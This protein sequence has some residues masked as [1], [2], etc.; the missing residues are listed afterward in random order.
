M[1]NPQII[2]FSVWPH[3]PCERVSSHFHY[4]FD[5][6]RTFGRMDK[7]TRLQH[8]H[9]SVLHPAIYFIPI[10]TFMCSSKIGRGNLALVGPMNSEQ[11]NISSAHHSLSKDIETMVLM[12]NF[13]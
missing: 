4:E 8:V 9:R 6:E 3:N 7:P 1:L 12:V 13:S 10:Y 2:S 11:G 5:D